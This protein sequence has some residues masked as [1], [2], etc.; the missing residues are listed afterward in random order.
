MSH[1]TVLDASVPEDLLSAA[2]RS[3][4]DAEVFWGREEAVTA[5]FVGE[6]E[7]A[8]KLDAEAIS[9]R[10]ISSG[11]FGHA[12]YQGA[13]PRLDVNALV[14][15]ATAAADGGRLAPPTFWKERETGID[16]ATFDEDVAALGE[17]DLRRLARQATARL[18]DVLGNV[19]AQVAVRRLL[20]STL[21][22]TRMCERRSEKTILQFQMRVGPMPD[23]GATW[24]EMWATSRAPDDPLS[25]L[26]NVVWKATVGRTIATLPPTPCRVVLGPRAVAVALRWLCET[27]TGTAVLEGRSRFDATMLGEAV[28]SE[29]LTI[30][31]N[32]L[33][34][35]APPSGAYDGEGL[36]RARRTLVEG[37]ALSALLLDLSSAYQ[38]ELEPTAAAARGLDT[39][40]LPAPSF[41][42]L[43]PGVEGFE[44]LLS[45][46]EG[47]IYVD[48]LV[49]KDG[50]DA[51]GDFN[52]PVTA[53]FVIR[54][55]RPSGWV[56]EVSVIGNIYDLFRRQVIAVGSDRV[57]S[58]SACCGSIAFEDVIIE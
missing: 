19:P 10:V 57:A 21:L 32:P 39:P 35:W 36:P 2:L 14:R 50:P 8:Q 38:L 52:A 53:A 55:G 7:Q 1:P 37:G 42:E 41:L 9:L 46:C 34:P 48:G 51:D 18:R 24:A 25:A 56:G 44:G 15:K 12:S 23:S 3:T 13:I 6:K 31:D 11:R 16:V 20:R 26:G 43:A 47:G 29:R 40:P 49:E 54:D 22:M 45:S 27:L 33:R 4:R 5:A 28:L 30:I 58:Q 17:G